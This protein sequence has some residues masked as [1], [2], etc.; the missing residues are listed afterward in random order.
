MADS[1][2]PNDGEPD[3]M[4]VFDRNEPKIT[5]A[6]GRISCVSAIPARPSAI[7]CTSVAGIDTGDIAPMSRN[8]VTITAWF[9]LHVLV[10]R[11]RAC[12][13]R[14]AAASCTLMSDTDADVC[15][16]ASLPPKR[17]SP[18]ADRVDPR[19]G[20]LVTE[21]MYGLSDRVCSA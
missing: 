5:G 15:S 14:S 13:R 3:C 12:G 20:P 6:P 8:G 19:S 17:I 18:I 4:S 10:Q 11:P 16:I 2:V 9:A 7:C 21:P 1:G